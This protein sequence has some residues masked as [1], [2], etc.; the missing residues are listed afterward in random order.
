MIR[1]EGKVQ[2]P[3]YYTS[4]ALR[5]AEGRYPL[6]EK[7]AFAPITAS[8]TLRHYFQA[9]VIN[10]MTDHPLKKAMNKLEVVRRLIQWAV[11]LSE[12]D[13]R[14][15]PWHAIKAQALANFIAEFTPSCS[16]IEGRKDGKK[17]V[18]HVDG[19]AT[20]HAGGIGVVMQSPEGDKLK[21]KIRLQYQATNNEV[22]YEA[23]LKG[24]ELAKSVEAK[25][26]L[27]LGD[28]QLIMGQLNGCMRQRKDE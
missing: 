14:Y 26:I 3:V 24:L 15:Q 22:E 25:S 18:V 27:V 1:K 4:K 17:W 16:D 20:Q 6:I 5:G 11:E 13:I 8:R 23:L 12:F 19:S 10:V 2:K 28:S 9:Y 7:L 21:H